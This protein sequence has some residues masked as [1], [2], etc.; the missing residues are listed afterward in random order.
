MLARIATR[1][2]LGSISI[3]R[4]LSTQPILRRPAAATE[5]ET[6]SVD[7]GPGRRSGWTGRSVFTLAAA[8]G[9]LGFGV[10]ALALSGSSRDA[11][12]QADIASKRIPKA[13]FASVSRM[14][15]ALEK[16][17]RE[18]KII[19]EE[20]D[21]ISIDPEDL[22]AHGYSEWSSVNPA[23][24]PVAVAYPRSTEQVSVLVRICNEY[25][26]PVIPYSGGSSLEGHFSAPYGGVSVDFAY[27]DKIIKFHKDDMDIVVQP[28]VGW[29]DLNAQLSEMK[30]GLFFPCSGTNAVRYGTMKDWIINLTVVLADG[31]VIKTRRR[32]RK[33]SAG[34][35]LNSLFVGSEGTLGL[36]TEVTLKLA[37]VPEE[38]SVAVVSFPS[39]RDAASAAAQIVQTGI[40]VAAMEIM[41]E[42][43]MKVINLGGATAPKVW[44]E[45]PTLFFKFSGTKVS[46]KDNISRVQSITKANKGSNFEFA[47]DERE[48]KLLWSARKEALWSM[49]SL[50]AEGEEVS[51]PFSRLVDLI[52]ISKK[53]MDDLGLFASVLGH[54]GD[55]NFHESIMYN[56]QKKDE[57]EKVEKCVKNMVNRAIDM[58]GTCTGE[59][60]IGW[61]KKDSL[62]REVGLDTLG[63]MKAIKLALDPHWILNP[64]K[65]FDLPDQDL[66]TTT[67]L[68]TM[69]IETMEEGAA[70]Q[71]VAPQIST[72][73]AEKQY[74]EQWHSV[75]IRV[76]GLPHT[77]KTSDL[78][79][80]FQEYGCVVNIEIKENTMGRRGLT[81]DLIF[82]PPPSQA[83]L[84]VLKISIGGKP[85]NVRVHVSGRQSPAWDPKNRTAEG[86]LYPSYIRLEP[87][88]LQFGVLENENKFVNMRT[89]RTPVPFYL[90]MRKKKLEMQFI[91][92]IPDPRRTNE[93]I[94]HRE[95]IGK[96][97]A[98]TEWKIV[99]SLSHMTEIISIND[100][101]DDTLSAVLP[102]PSPPVVYKKKDI[103]KS[104]DANRNNWS[105]IDSWVR[106]VEITYDSSWNKKNQ[107]SL[108]GLPHQFIDIGKWTA[109]KIVMFRSASVLETW[110]LVQKAL[111][112]SNIS[113]RVCSSNAFQTVEARK[114]N[115]WNILDSKAADTTSTNLA[116]L[117]STEAISLPFD[118]RYQLEVCISQG[119]LNEINL[120]KEFLHR[121]S[122]LSN[123]RIGQRNRARDLLTYVA[124]S[125]G[126]DKTDDRV[127]R[128]YPRRFY[129]PLVLF[130]D[131]KALSRF[132]EIGV[133]SEHCVLVR[134]VIVTPSTMYLI[135]RHFSKET[136]RFLRVQFLDELVKGQIFASPDHDREISLFNRVWRTLWNGI[137]VGGRHY[138]FL[139]FGNSQFRENGA[140]FFA[141]TDYL[142]CAQIRESMGDFDH[143]KIVAKYI[144][145][146]GLCFSTTRA[147]QGI[148]IGQQII[149]IDDIERNG[150]CF[151][152][153]VGKISPILAKYV[154]KHLRLNTK[155][156]PS[157]F[158]IRLGGSKGM[159]VVDPRLSFNEIAIRPSQ[160][161][162]ESISK[163]LEIINHSRFSGATLNR[164]TITNLSSLGVKDEVFLRMQE[165]QLKDYDLAMED[166]N[167]GITTTLAQMIMDGFMET[168]EPFFM[169]ILHTWRAWSL[170]LLREKARI[171]VEKGAFVFGCVDE[172]QTL[173]G[174][175]EPAAKK[176]EDGTP[177]GAAE[178]LPQ[179]FLQVP[180][181]GVHSQDLDSYVVITGR[182]V[183]GR[184]PSLHPGDLRVVEAVDVPELHHIRDCVV[185]P[186]TGDR[187]IPSMCSGGDLDGD[188]FFV[189]WD[190]ELIPP[191]MNH[192]PMIQTPMEPKVLI[193]DVQAKDLIEFF[194]TYMKNDSLKRIALAW[195][196]Q[197]DNLPAGP[198]DPYCVRL[199]QLHSNA[200][201]YNKSGRPAHLEER[202]VPKK[203]PHFMEK[204]SWKTYHSWRILGRLYDA[205]APGKFLWH[206]RDTFDERILRRFDVAD[207]ML[208]KAR[209]IKRQHDT[210][211]RQIMNQ[212]EIG[213][214]YEVWS[215]FVLTKPRVG[216]DYKVQ[217]TM[218]PVVA[219]HRERFRNACIRVAGSREPQVLY[220]FIAAMY[221]V[222]W[223]EVK[224]WTSPD[225]ENK[226]KPFQTAPMISFPWQDFELESMP[227]VSTAAFDNEYRDDE[228][229]RLVCTGVFD[230]ELEEIEPLQD[231]PTMG[232]ETPP[233]TPLALNFKGQ[234]E[235]GEEDE[236]DEDVEGGGEEAEVLEEVRT[237]I[238]ALLDLTSD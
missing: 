205:V 216:S 15:E 52:E 30:S 163:T 17:R 1:R 191:E 188:D 118:V 13:R 69:G 97:E 12:Q 43:Q 59:H 178:E 57:F 144:A 68:K 71:S 85:Y 146:L 6:E 42:V 230:A 213:T 220:R 27:M 225:L 150:W 151:T 129:D 10:A 109:Y 192:P 207:E 233:D 47:R 187:D 4:G 194:V 28:S 136:D 143:I 87:D 89:C 190:P 164:Q 16:M 70:R 20:E 139:A 206:L 159:L 14:E 33:S 166:P 62:I 204:P 72:A 221:R 40:P 125:N 103:S 34:Y 79:N 61:G 95:P 100:N 203:F 217:E 180:R 54:I 165:K 219:G 224:I 3:R 155:V 112:D 90:D 67:Y 167:N 133:P 158:H 161:K 93:Q 117:A 130:S 121:L 160:K 84:G 215:T 234:V 141:P 44:K 181:S 200:V 138:E 176:S 120:D 132:P 116:L 8:T 183:L 22:H 105:D 149:E 35:N 156:V 31:T 63:V 236:H 173:R 19:G 223:E 135:L 127:S 66:C 113:T 5:T 147:P 177:E 60:S 77:V 45:A 46:V 131:K 107:V 55:G 174:Y 58:D 122:D 211:L 186:S 196:A 208:R 82:S 73:Y 80:R 170:R 237:G 142:T 210:A 114:T 2:L 182:C 198:K 157:A 232:P 124:E 11:A 49:L 7:T 29:Q 199:A 78:W 102:L 175:C 48:Q 32:P 152:D 202:L 98:P 228:Y 189:I 23:G 153:G 37:V 99:I 162:F 88:F 197:A 9:V 51:V 148:P 126:P 201:D 169:C 145:R 53:E 64:G 86:A 235:E 218:G 39:I 195:L 222:T 83:C 123:K 25:R 108:R 94:E 229:E 193:R 140:W 179:I 171:V 96:W 50:R 154:A 227:R 128:I 56:R 38:T 134:K 76:T 41:D 81:A 106:A 101:E 18:L 168:K 184:N 92:N 91:C 110:D 21:I 65:I 238:D 115:F 137:D 209:I 74:W 26:I 104:H 172:T 36:V 212:R 231:S 75:R 24:L 119:Y 185:F 226:E 111:L 214:E